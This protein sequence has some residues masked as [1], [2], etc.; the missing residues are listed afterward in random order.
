MAVEQVGGDHYSKRGGTEYQ[1]WD[2]VADLGMDYY[3]ANA[4]KYVM[5]WRDKNGIV[6]LKKAVTYIKKRLELTEAGRLPIEPN[7]FWEDGKSIV[8]MRD[9]KNAETLKKFNELHQV[10]KVEEEVMLLLCLY[11]HEND[12]LTSAISLLEEIIAS[13]GEASTRYVNQS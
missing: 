13:E 1:H 7:K 8:S 11:S 4:T 2:L 5:R 9:E 3:M 6:D 12:A 10:D